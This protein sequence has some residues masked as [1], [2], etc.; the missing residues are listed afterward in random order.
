MKKTIPT[1]KNHEAYAS[2]DSDYDKRKQHGDATS[3]SAFVMSRELEKISGG[4]GHASLGENVVDREEKGRAIFDYYRKLVGFDHKTRVLEYGCGSLRVG[5]VFIDYLEPGHFFGMDVE[6]GLIEIGKKMLPANVLAEKRPTL[7][8]IGSEAVDRALAFQADFIYANSVAFHVHPD[9][10]ENFCINLAKVASKPDAILIFDARL[11]ETPLRYNSRGWAWP[12]ELYKEL[13][14]P[15][16]LVNVHNAK[17]YKKVENC[18]AANLEFRSRAGISLVKSAG[19]S[20]SEPPRTRT[21]QFQTES[22]PKAHPMSDNG[23]NEAFE[24]ADQAFREFQTKNP[25][26]SFGRYATEKQLEAIKRGSPHP[27][28]GKKLKSNPDWLTAGKATF[29]GHVRRYNIKPNHKVADYGCGSLR[30]GAHFIRYLEPEHYFGIDVIMGFI[31]IGIEGLGE[32]VIREKKPMF[33]DFST[34]READ[35]EKFDADLVYSTACVFQIHP[36]EQEEMFRNFEM[37]ARK[38]G[39]RLIFDTMIA[40]E[41]VRYRNSAWAWPQDH[42]LKNLPDFEL[43]EARPNGAREEAGH[44]M[45]WTWFTFQRKG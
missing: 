34:L 43:I 3:Y 29:D 25:K 28:L 40:D 8:D 37:I 27:T 32:E 33:R 9:D 38:P 31:E 42:Y 1:P 19:D 24:R 23:V 7:T 21:S 35:A 17:P 30:L 22:Q 15:L 13:L 18:I 12:L 20:S 41:L 5:S 36:N 4:V 39:S 26:V 45:E 11:S 44:P 2:H 6:P 10:L 16:E 14:S